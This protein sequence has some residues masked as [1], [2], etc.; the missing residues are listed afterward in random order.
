[1]AEAKKEAFEEGATAYLVEKVKEALAEGGG[2]QKSMTDE[3]FLEFMREKGGA[4][5]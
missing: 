1:M 3:Q 5:G 2:G 4:N